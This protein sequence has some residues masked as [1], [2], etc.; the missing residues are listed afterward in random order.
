MCDQ[1]S[2]GSCFCSTIDVMGFP[3]LFSLFSL[4]LM[5][6]QR[7][8]YLSMEFYMGR[9]LTNAMVN[10]GIDSPVEEAL[11]EVSYAHLHLVTCN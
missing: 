4:S 1:H 5:K 9:S 10:L 8:Y 7:C 11:Y 3:L 6:L 2:N